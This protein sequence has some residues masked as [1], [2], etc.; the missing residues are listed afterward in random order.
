M[1]GY[2]AKIQSDGSLVVRG[3]LK[4]KELAGDNWPPTASM[5]TLKWL[6]AE[7]FKN[8]ARVHQLYFIGAF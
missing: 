1:D 4:N 2:K 5:I 7:G 8:K 3:Y 6:L